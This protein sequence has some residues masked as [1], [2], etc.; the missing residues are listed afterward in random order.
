MH[1]QLFLHR[2]H[3]EPYPLSK[4]KR[5]CNHWPPCFT[6]RNLML[7][8]WTVWEMIGS[9]AYIHV[10]LYS[11]KKRERESWGGW[12]Q[13]YTCVSDI[14]ET[15]VLHTLAGN[16][17]VVCVWYQLSECMRTIIDSYGALKIQNTTLYLPEWTYKP[18][19]IGPTGNTLTIHHV[20][21][22]L[23]LV[24]VQWYLCFCKHTAVYIELQLW[25]QVYIT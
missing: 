25:F 1:W 23:W 7:Q 9:P 14:Q 4:K 20:Q 6:M 18:M 3:K 5:Y 11:S 19:L 13:S 22:C 8:H 12:L 24:W 17:M 21:S 2:Q 10:I 15:G 16:Y